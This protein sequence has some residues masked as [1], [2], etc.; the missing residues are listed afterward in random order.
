[1]GGKRKNYYGEG[2]DAM[3]MWVNLND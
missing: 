3:V 1:Y 2:E